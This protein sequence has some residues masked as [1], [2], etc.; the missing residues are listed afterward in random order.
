MASSGAVRVCFVGE[1]PTFWVRFRVAFQQ[2]KYTRVF[3]LLVS[4]RLS[5]LQIAFFL[6]MRAAWC[7]ATRRV[8]PSLPQAMKPGESLTLPG[9]DCT[10]NSA[11]AVEPSTRGRK[12]CSPCRT[13]GA[14]I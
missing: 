13:L 6:S 8:D 11:D 3:F 10:I 14:M 2:E 9:T 1:P 7:T 5:C 4:L 12:V